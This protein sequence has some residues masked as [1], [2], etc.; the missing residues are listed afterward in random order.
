M[1]L[2]RR[3]AGAATDGGAALLTRHDFRAARKA[4]GWTQGQ[5]AERAETEQATVSRLELGAR[6]PEEVRARIAAALTTEEG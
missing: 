1:V 5:L 4:R 3:P 2:E 6:V